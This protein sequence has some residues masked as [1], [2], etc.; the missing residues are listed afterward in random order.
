MLD[1]RTQPG[2][3]PISQTLAVIGGVARRCERGDSSR[4]MALPPSGGRSRLDDV[5]RRAGVSLSTA[6][7]VI[8]DN[9]YPVAKATRQR[10][11]EAV[12]ELSYSPSVLARAL[13]TKRTQIVGVIV[14]DVEDPYF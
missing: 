1:C 3:R 14:G 6:S 5:A 12:R 9:G 10:V 7:R 4:T 8:N 11:L 2:R 13:V